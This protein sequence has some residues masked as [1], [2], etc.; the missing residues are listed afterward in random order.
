MSSTPVPSSCH[1]RSSAAFADRPG[2]RVTA[3]ISTPAASTTR[4]RRRCRPRRLPSSA[5]PRNPRAALRHRRRGDAG[6]DD[7]QAGRAD[8]RRR[9]HRE[10]GNASRRHR[11]T[12][13]RIERRARPLERR[14]CRRLRAAETS[15]KLPARAPAAGRRITT[16]AGEASAFQRVGDEGQLPS[17]ATQRGSGHPL[18]LLGTGAEEARVVAASQANSRDPDD[19][20]EKREGPNIQV[21]RRPTPPAD[22]KRSGANAPPRRWRRR[23]RGRRARADRRASNRERPSWR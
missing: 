19:R 18:V 15:S 6:P 11:P 9:S 4:R 16:P 5:R 2:R 17:A 22:P 23:R 14:E 10:I 21:V 8:H 12:T 1:G 20:E 13:T 3:T 7:V